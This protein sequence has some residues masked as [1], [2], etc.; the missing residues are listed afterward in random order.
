[1]APGDAGDAMAGGET[2]I[3]A[4]MG[5]RGCV[6]DA[7][8][9]FAVRDACA[10]ARIDVANIDVLAGLQRQETDG[11]L[12]A[13]AGLLQTQ[14]LLYHPDTLKLAGG[15]CVTQSGRSMR[16]TGVPSVAE[17]AALCAAGPQG[18]LILPRIAHPT[19]TVAL[20]QSPGAT[21]P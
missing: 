13:A 16:A 19:V 11:A 1:M 10:R 8:I 14:V 20:A 2:V 3:A 9:T 12:S 17:A 15:R 18:Y 4:G 5:A 21:R 7:E 6:T